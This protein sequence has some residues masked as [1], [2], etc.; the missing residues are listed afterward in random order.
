MQVEE[1]DAEAA[2]LKAEAA[3]RR[4]AAEAVSLLEQDPV[5][6]VKIAVAA[7][8]QMSTVEA[9]DALRAALHAIRL[10]ETVTHEIDEVTQIAFSSNGALAALANPYGDIEVRE[11][12]SGNVVFSRNL[13]SPARRI[14]FSPNRRHWLIVGAENGAASIWDMTTG[15]DIAVLQHRS[16]EPVTAVAISP[17]NQYAFTGTWGDNAIHLWSLPEGNHI[18]S[19]SR[20]AMTPWTIAIKPDQTLIAVGGSLEGEVTL[21]DGMLETHIHSWQAHDS[22]ITDLAFSPDGTRLALGNIDRDI[23]V[24]DITSVARIAIYDS[25]RDAQT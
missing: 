14:A 25:N 24:W 18:R 19:L 3:S 2:G 9:G 21:W 7:Y 10:T 23:S 15:E 16:G 20:K 1:L 6:G 22:M 8:Q 4:I 13:D 11:S 5:L 12:S 17:D